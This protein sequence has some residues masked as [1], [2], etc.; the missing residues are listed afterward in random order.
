MAVYGTNYSSED[1]LAECT[2]VNVIPS[3]ASIDEMAYHVLESTEEDFNKIWMEAGVRELAYM[4]ENHTEMIYESSSKS[5]I[6]NKITNAFKEMWKKIQGMIEKA[7]NNFAKKAAEFKSKILKGLNKNFLK[8]RFENLKSDKDLGR[9]YKE[10]TNIETNCITNLA[11]AINKTI[12]YGDDEMMKLYADATNENDPKKISDEQIEKVVKS[13]I[14]E[15]AGTEVDNVSTMVT[16]IRTKFCGEMVDV[17]G[18]WLKKENVYTKVLEEVSNLPKTKRDLKNSYNVLKKA[19]NEGI[20]KCKSKSEGNLFKPDMFSKMAKGF[21]DIR[22]IAIK[23][24]Q[25]LI[26]MLNERNAF[27]RG[28]IFKVIGTKPV[29]E[30]AYYAE[31]ATTIDGVSSLFDF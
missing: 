29:K 31:S 10:Y 20:K 17:K 1:Y 19:I 9:T 30:S 21:K 16:T 15:I 22:Q 27:F 26:S 7:L 4:E 3:Y 25:A 14:R 6:V 8:K 23:A 24:E 13:I 12:N 2:P 28:V 5:G 11:G 18:E